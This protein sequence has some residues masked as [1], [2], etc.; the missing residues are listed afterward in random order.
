MKEITPQEADQTI[1][2]KVNRWRK[3][4]CGLYVEEEH[5][6]TDFGNLPK[7]FCRPSCWNP[8]TNANHTHEA[9]K[10]YGHEFGIAYGKGGYCVSIYGVAIKCRATSESFPHAACEAL[11][12]AILGEPVRIK[13][14]QD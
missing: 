8:S 1:A 4:A 7:F 10:A 5:E 11:C 3:H 12:S 6:Y 2:E 9:L 14:I 13:C